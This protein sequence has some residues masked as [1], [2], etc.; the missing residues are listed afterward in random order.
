M[1]L[2]DS[3][4]HS[5]LRGQRLDIRKG[6]GLDLCAVADLQLS[7]QRQT[8][9]SR[10]QISRAASQP[11]PIAVRQVSAEGKLCQ[12]AI[13]SFEAVRIGEKMVLLCQLQSLFSIGVHL[14]AKKR[15][16]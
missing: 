5:M 4:W 1:Y 8:T 15:E 7:H 16:F 6:G 3:P 13:F 2:F 10:H 9:A 14:I 11:P 12:T